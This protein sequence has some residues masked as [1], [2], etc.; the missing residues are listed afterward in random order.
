MVN[1][2]MS[3]TGWIWLGACL[4]RGPRTARRSDSRIDNICLAKPR[5]RQPVWRYLI[6]C[7]TQQGQW[8]SRRNRVCAACGSRPPGRPVM[9]LWPVTPCK[10]S[11]HS[12]VMHADGRVLRSADQAT[13]MGMPSAVLNHQAASL[14]PKLRGVPAAL[15]R[16][17]DIL[18]VGPAV[19]VRCPPSGVN[20]SGL[21]RGP[22]N[23]R[24]NAIHA[25]RFPYVIH[26]SNFHRA[27]C[28]MPYMHE[29]IEASWTNSAY[30]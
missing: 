23:T 27:Y 3:S 13:A 24:L 6:L 5:D 22:G 15:A 21:R 1:A 16:R 14:L 9:L 2:G 25:F 28:V 19:P 29:R 8:L 26:N 11:G 12:D 20:P 30:S 18:P 4:R 17:T 7:P 10:A